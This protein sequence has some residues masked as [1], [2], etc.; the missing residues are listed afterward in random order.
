MFQTNTFKLLRHKPLITL[1]V[2]SVLA[3]ATTGLATAGSSDRGIF[4]DPIWVGDG[5]GCDYSSLAV[6][7]DE[8][9]EFE[10][11]RVTMDGPFD[12]TP[13]VIDKSVALFGGYE[14][15]GDSLASGKTRLGG[16]LA[17]EE[18]IVKVENG[19]SELEVSLTNFTIAG[20]NTTSHDV[21]NGAGIHVTGNHK[22]SII[23]SR[24]VLN[25]SGNHGG[26][27]FAGDGADVE[28]AGTSEI[29]SNIAVNGGGIACVD[30]TVEVGR[31]VRIAQNTANDP[32]DDATPGN[33]NSGVG[34]GIF[35]NGCDLR[36]YAGET[37][38]S[39][40]VENDAQKFGGG[41]YAIGNSDVLIDGVGGGVTAST[42]PALIRGNQSGW[43]AGGIE[44][45]DASEAVLINTILEGNIG[46][47]EGPVEVRPAG[48]LRVSNGASLE[49]T[50]DP[51]IRCTDRRDGGSLSCSKIIANESIN[52]TVFVSD[53]SVTIRRTEI[54][55]NQ[56]VG[57]ATAVITARA[58]SGLLLESALIAN[59]DSSEGASLRRIL[60]VR[61]TDDVALQWTTIANN[62]GSLNELIR[63]RADG[64]DSATAT[65]EGML[66]FQPDVVTVRS[67]GSGD[68]E[69]TRVAC[70]MS[71]EIQTIEDNALEE[72]A[73]L[74]YQLQ[75]ADPFFSNPSE[76][77]YRL[78]SGSPAIDACDEIGSPIFLIPP[79]H[80]IDGNQRGVAYLQQT[81]ETVFDLGAFERG[82]EIL[83]RDRFEAHD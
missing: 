9:E 38:G 76:G 66:F 75:E 61:D 35:A 17:D 48:A 6:A 59:N 83:L 41:I 24:I 7:L 18:R 3:V 80:D 19:A 62:K 45:T 12:E 28:V 39:G 81:E 79:E 49:M 5:T 33:P 27:I 26:A 44:L 82:G 50:T 20:G 21:G 15:C 57:S 25:F 36:V 43:G 32:D 23:S 42:E 37:G 1:T 58:G 68:Q 70:V 78:Q 22:V 56:Q 54:I 63:L 55:D 46:D 74:I 13:Y 40:I 69:L 4:P 51:G 52:E 72:P 60:E 11:I 67:S 10:W 30:A 29:E 64:D 14:N 31:D 8:A 53:A 47:P 77:N 73:G 2:F 34:G 16:V 65:L 71:H